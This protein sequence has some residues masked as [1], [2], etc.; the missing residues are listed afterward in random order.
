MSLKA[1]VNALYQA[2]VGST[3]VRYRQHPTGVAGVAVADDAAWDEII[4]STIITDA[5]HHLAG[6]LAFGPGAGAD[7]EQII[8]EGVG[9]ADG[10]A[11]AAATL[12]VEMQMGVDWTSAVGLAA[13][14]H[15]WML[16]VPIRV[17]QAADR[18]AGRISASPTGGIAVTLSIEVITGLGT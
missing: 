13:Q 2:Q 17:E 3:E 4:A 12:L 1:L 14:V 8:A 7:V 11:V 18:H 15:P 16:P 10:A 6:L 5:F 9:G